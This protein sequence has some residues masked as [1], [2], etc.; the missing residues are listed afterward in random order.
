MN[1]VRSCP[2]GHPRIPENRTNADK[3][4][5][6]AAERRHKLSE[7]NRAAKRLQKDRER[8]QINIKLR[9][10]ATRSTIQ[11]D[12]YWENRRVD[13]IFNLM[14]QLELATS[15]AERNAIQSAINELS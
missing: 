14:D 15:K 4:K 2:N 5:V 8:T 12:I 11:E 6:C 3:C 1:S 13:K 7:R 10:S 9:G